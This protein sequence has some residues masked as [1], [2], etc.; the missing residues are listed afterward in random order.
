MIAVLC[1]EWASFSGLKIEER[2]ALPE[3]GPKQVKIAVEAAGVSYVDLLMIAG[4]YQIKPSLPF[5]PGG[6]VA[7]KVLQA[8]KECRR[9]QVGQE[10]YAAT[11][12][13]AY[14]S[15]VVVEEDQVFPM[16]RGLSMPEAASS[17]SAFGTSYH[18]L[19]DRAD[20]QSGER[21]LIFGASGGL[22]SAA[23]QVAQHIGAEVIAV[24]TS[25]SK[26]KHL[27]R[28]G[29]QTIVCRSAQSLSE[30]L[31]EQQ[32][33]V[34]FDTIGGAYSEAAFRAL[35]PGGRHLVLGFVSGR[36]PNLPLNLPL[37]KMAEV[38]GVFWSRFR[39][40]QPTANRKNFG[41]ISNLLAQKKI[42]P[43]LTKT[44]PLDEYKH[45]LMQLK[46]SKVMG[47]LALLMP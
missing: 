27:D 32:I 10:V 17:V 37:L 11:T 6:E 34:V 38:R 7:G 39:R 19:V 24:T 13:G 18:A 26:Q 14:A 21:V 33:H 42:K 5:T 9:L 35:A 2:A 16:P 36:I 29:A 23:V 12:L 41:I 4:K 3:P 28:L 45:A 40:E 44:Y 46:K 31:K 43:C 25:S 22:G 15:E 8:G 30:Q 47:K 20:L 1:S